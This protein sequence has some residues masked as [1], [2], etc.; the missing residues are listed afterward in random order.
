MEVFAREDKTRRLGGHITWL[1]DVA[2]DYE[3]ETIQI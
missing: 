3:V 2:E 1:F